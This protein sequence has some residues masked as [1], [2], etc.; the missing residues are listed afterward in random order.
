MNALTRQFAESTASLRLL[1][2]STE[3]LA[4]DALLAVFKLRDRLVA[5]DCN[6]AACRIERIMDDLEAEVRGLFR[7]G[8]D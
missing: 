6:H 5:R 3:A 4:D 1:E 7:N 2:P 8:A